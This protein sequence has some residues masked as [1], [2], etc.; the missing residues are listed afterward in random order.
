MH[1]EI[2]PFLPPYPVYW[3]IGFQRIPS[4]S[5]GLCCDI[6]FII[7]KYINL[8][9]FLLLFNQIGQ[10]FIS[11]I[12]SFKEQTFFI[13]S[14]YSIVVSNSLIYILIITF[15][16]SLVLDLAHSCLSWRLRC[17]IRILTCNLQGFLF[18][19]FFM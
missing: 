19:S 9:L 4:C 12:Y 10:R 7:S 2:N 16:P 6:P 1:Q 13:D 18:V 3:N 5:F 11:L 14:L 15:F 17:I 8:G